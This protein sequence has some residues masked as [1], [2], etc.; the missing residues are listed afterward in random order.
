MKHIIYKILDFILR[1]K[2]V[3][4]TISGTSIRLPTRYFRYYPSDYEQ[5]NILFFKRNIKKGDCVVDIGAQIGLMTK[6]FSDLV[7]K[8]GKVYA[9]EPEAQTFELLKKTISINNIA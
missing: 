8:E 5:E 2:G 6:I 7:G 1:G 4:T 9:F 3:K